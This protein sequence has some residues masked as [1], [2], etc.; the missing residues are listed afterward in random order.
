M[1]SLDDYNFTGKM[2]EKYFEPADVGRVNEVVVEGHDGVVMVIDS[3]EGKDSSRE[4]YYE[5]DSNLFDFYG[6]YALKFDTYFFVFGFV[7]CLEDHLQEKMR[8]F[9]AAEIREV[10]WSRTISVNSQP[11]PRLL[12]RL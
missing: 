7:E 2:V 9:T 6:F 8:R 5:I 1:T 3:S 4:I 11:L 10:G 12:K